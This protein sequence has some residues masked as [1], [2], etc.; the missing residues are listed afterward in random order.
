[1]A[2]AS[3]RRPRRA[4]S[5]A[6]A[7]LPT[8]SRCT[9][10][11]YVPASGRSRGARVSFLP[12]VLRPVLVDPGRLCPCPGSSR[13][14]GPCPPSRGAH[15]PAPLG[16]LP[17]SS[18]R[19][20]LWRPEATLLAPAWSSRLSAGPLRCPT[21]P[22]AS[23]PRGRRSGASSFRFCDPLRGV[24]APWLPFRPGS[25]PSARTPSS[26]G[27]GVPAAVAAGFGLPAP[28]GCRF[29]TLAPVPSTTL[30]PSRGSSSPAPSTASRRP[31]P[32]AS[33]PK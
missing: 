22:G 29:A 19:R 21:H 7:R 2:T 24:P 33:S 9:R 28:V 6:S 18:R 12:S 11:S 15:R 4:A 8:A 27:A 20:P 23:S 25:L 16:P 30:P 13:I 5:S 3:F 17:P 26:C 10:S 31:S 14:G 32:T 1:M